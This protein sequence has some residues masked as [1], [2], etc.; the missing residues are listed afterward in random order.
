M[1]TVL[2]ETANLTAQNQ[3]TIPTAFR[4]ALQL[5]GGRSVV[6]FSLRKDGSVLLSKRSTARKGRP[7][8][9]LASFLKLLDE[10]MR[11]RPERIKAMSP[12]FLKKIQRLVRNVK[13]DLDA[14]LSSRK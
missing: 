1:A 4:K 8:D 13:V 5:Q 14:P 6:S 12:A 11:R 10:D 9:S 7:E 2:E 3:I